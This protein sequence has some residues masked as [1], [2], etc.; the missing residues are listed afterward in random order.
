MLQSPTSYQG[1]KTRIAPQIVKILRN[2]AISNT[3]FYD[4]CCGSGAITL[5]LMNQGIP[6]S[7]IVMCDAGPWGKFWSE[8]GQG[9]FDV[10]L[11][12]QMV[13]EIPKDPH[14]IKDHMQTLAKRNPSEAT[15][16]TF[17]LLQAASFGSKPIWIENDKWQNCSFRSYWQPTETSNRRSPVNPMMPMPNTLLTR[18]KELVAKC[19][20]LA[21]FHSRIED[22][23]I[24]PNSRVYIDPPYRNTTQYGHDTDAVAVAK[25]LASKKCGILSFI[26]EG[27][28]LSE[29]ATLLAT[30]GDR[31]KGGISGNKKVKPNEE[32]LSVFDSEPVLLAM[33]NGISM[34]NLLPR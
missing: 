21:A 28:P 30:S 7:Q 18:T 34:L 19:R 29:H 26:S 14:Q 9:T 16:Q 27:I 31:K 22:V 20:G 3:I 2:T 25:N 13:S 23:Q 33:I 1:A 10:Q 24:Q 32:W 12:E 6:A 8:I 11:L 15:T 5:E 17:L 4:L